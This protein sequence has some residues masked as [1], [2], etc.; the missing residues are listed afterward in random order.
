MTPPLLP[1]LPFDRTWQRRDALYTLF[2]AW[3][4]LLVCFGV[5]GLLGYAASFVW[6]GAYR[7]TQVVY[8]ALNPYRAYSDAGFLAL[9]KPKYANLDNYHYWQMSQ[10][11]TFI[12]SD[13]VLRAAQ[14][15]LPAGDWQNVGLEDLRASLS[16]EWRTAGEW[17][18]SAVDSQAAAARQL[19]EAWSRAAAAQVEQAVSSAQQLISLDQALQA[20]TARLLQAQARLGLLSAAPP[21]W[22]AWQAQ[23]AAQP[24]SPLSPDLQWQMAGLALN[25]A[26]D[27]PA[28]SALLAAQ[29]HAGDPAALAAAWLDRLA[30]QAALDAALLPEQVAQLTREQNDLQAAYSHAQTES[31]GLSP[32]LSIERIGAPE[33]QTLR[34]AALLALV[35]AVLGLLVGLIVALGRIARRPQAAA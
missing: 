7:S 4:G 15:D 31:A 19:S 5:G 34:P 18:L 12:L 23:L 13:R 10:L 6:P 30:A 21:R 33:L 14:Q 20:T 3:V 35:G 2:H 9:S 25:L 11:N 8:V 32:N 22:Q 28:W 16:A 26:D 24:A 29:P 1:L 17:D 27:S